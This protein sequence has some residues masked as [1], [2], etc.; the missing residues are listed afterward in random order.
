MSFIYKIINNINN[1]IYVG[2]TNLTIQERFNQHCRDSQKISEQTRPLYRAMN[3]YGIEN[4]TIELIEECPTDLASFK[5]QYWIGYYKGYE[6]G[7]NAT[8]GGDGIQ[9]FNHFE[10]AKK[11]KEIL[12]PKE[13]AKLYG[14]S[15]DTIYIIAKEYNI[16]L[17]QGGQDNINSK[18][19]VYQYDK[20]T[21]KCLNSF[22]SVQKASEW[23]LKENI[24]HTL[25]SGVRSHI[26]E[27]ARGIRKTAYGY[28]WKYK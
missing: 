21:K 4:F 11:L 10:I 12:N 19:E 3:K 2:K 7:Y 15:L 6:N 25:N 26:S 16:K 8:K 1:K 9:L 20:I 23:L 24:I 27:A 17:P 28:I 18:K 13:V 22:E 14:C 5:E